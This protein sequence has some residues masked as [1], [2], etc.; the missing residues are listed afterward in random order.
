MHDF[1]AVVGS[2]LPQVRDL[3][4]TQPDA[5]AECGACK[6]RVRVEQ[7]VRTQRSRGHVSTRLCRVH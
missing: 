1:A 4:L 3:Q 2:G 5:T 7:Q 6:Q